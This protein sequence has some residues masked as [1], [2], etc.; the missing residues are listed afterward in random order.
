MKK[1]YIKAV[2]EA[3]FEEMERDPRVFLMGEDVRI[4]CFAATRGLCDTFGEERVIDTPI[5][6]LGVAGAG[7]G[8]AATGSRPIVDLMFGQFLMLAY[9]QISNQAN[10]MRYMFGG[11]TRI[12]IVYLV[13]NGTGPALGPHH[14][15]SVHPLFMN[16]PLVKV[17]MP[18]CPADAKGLLKSAIRDDN[19]VIFFN[20]TSLGGMKGE[21]PDDGAYLIPIGKGDI[22]RQGTDITLCTVGLMTN[23]CL[24]AGK[25]LE[26]EGIRAEVVDLRSLKP[27]DKA[28]VYESVKKTGRFLAV[29]ESYHTCGA[30]AEWVASVAEDMFEHLKCPPQRLSGKEIPIPFSPALQK[31]AVPNVEA[32]VDRVKRMVGRGAPR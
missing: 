9:D 26:P 23:V 2:Q 5:A 1:Y 30:G 32:V 4:G 6:E 14:S 13:Q 31:Y 25:I 8:A 7:V 22:K 3:L 16:I 15:N 21:V 11:Q 12:P 18:S 10:A 20:H 27:W 19:P 28:L 29:D 24:E 17:I